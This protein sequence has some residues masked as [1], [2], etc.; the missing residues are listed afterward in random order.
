MNFNIFKPA[1]I[2]PTTGNISFEK[3]FEAPKNSCSTC[4]DGKD[5]SSI[6]I[7][8]NTKVGKIRTLVFSD[9]TAI[10]ISD[11]NDGINGIDGNDGNDGVDGID[12]SNGLDGINGISII[13]ASIDTNPASPSYKQLLL[14][15]SDGSTINAGTVVGNNGADGVDGLNG[16]DG[17]S[18]TTVVLDIDNNL[19]VS[20]SDGSSVNAGQIQ[21][22]NSA[23]LISVDAV[24]AATA[25]GT[26]DA[27]SG[28]INISNAFAPKDDFFE[29]KLNNTYIDTNKFVFVQM[30]N[31]V[32]GSPS[33][34]FSHCVK[35][36]GNVFIYLKNVAHADFSGDFVLEFVIL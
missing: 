12:G 25:A 4:E 26:L 17:I 35:N 23:N 27:K 15:L 6:T 14:F 11:G 18:I 29:F 36:S 10:T 33:I 16:N 28:I 19:I 21:F 24:G 30:N 3:L 1:S 7:V 32:S 8:S 13:G 2:T 9:G 5:G 31:L 34:V 20:F 22:F